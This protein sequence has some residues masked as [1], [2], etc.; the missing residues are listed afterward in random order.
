MYTD[1]STVKA[2]LETAGCY[3]CWWARGVKEEVI[4]YCPGNILVDSLSWNPL[5]SAPVNDLVE[6]ESQIAIVQSAYN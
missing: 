1:H 2:G 3:A 4:L 5:G 6:E